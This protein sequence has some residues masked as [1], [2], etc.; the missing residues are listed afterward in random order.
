MGGRETNG[1]RE[2]AH[3]PHVVSVRE[4]KKIGAETERLA[5]GASRVE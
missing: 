3:A 4:E 1:E 2:V 5:V